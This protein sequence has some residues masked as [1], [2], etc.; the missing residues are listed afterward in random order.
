MWKINA[1]FRDFGRIFLVFIHSVVSLENAFG[2]T[3]PVKTGERVRDVFINLLP[4]VFVSY[5]HDNQTTHC[6]NNN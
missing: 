3:K 6:H 4:A 5:F 2:D 1:L